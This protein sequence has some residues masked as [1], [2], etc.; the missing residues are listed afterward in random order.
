MAYLGD[1]NWT[2]WTT[3]GECSKSCGSGVQARSRTCSNPSPAGDGKTCVGEA[4]EE[5][6]CNIKNCSSMSIF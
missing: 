5:K 1:G 3:W 6:D 2:E 4:S